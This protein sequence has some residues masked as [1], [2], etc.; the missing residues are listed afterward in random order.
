MVILVG[1]PPAEPRTD[2]ARRLK[3]LREHVV[4]NDR[5]KFAI[6]TGISLSTIGNYERGDR[7]PDADML[8]RYR[9]VSDISTDWLIT[10]EGDMFSSTRASQMKGAFGSAPIAGAATDL[11]Q[12]GMIAIPRYDE[13]RPSAGPGSVAV[14]EIPT[15]RVAFEQRWLVDI[16][17]QADA[18]VIL[19]AQGDSMAPTIPNGTPMLV[20]TS[21]TDVRNGFIYVFDIDGDLV[22]K[23]IERLPDGTF[24]LISDNRNYPT[25]N[26]SRETVT[27]MT[28]IGRVYAAVCKF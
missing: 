4:G 3:T 7:V 18:A 28:V 22:V 10:G 25:R 1:R 8:K 14:N 2:L 21:K 11:T 13:V 20:D 12:P 17:V 23:R 9:A 5:E 6:L 16:G 24:D 19:P 27:H 15:T 26:L